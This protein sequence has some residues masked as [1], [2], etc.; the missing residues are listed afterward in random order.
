VR[1][2]RT[3]EEK[4]HHSAWYSVRR[5]SATEAVGLVRPAHVAVTTPVTSLAPRTLAAPGKFTERAVD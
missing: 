3:A 4:G 2:S 5:G 1:T